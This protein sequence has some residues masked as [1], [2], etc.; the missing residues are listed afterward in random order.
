MS[1]LVEV[2]PPRYMKS[3][4]TATAPVVLPDLQSGRRRYFAGIITGGVLLALAA[5]EFLAG[6]VVMGR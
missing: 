5:A 4:P 6:L 1:A 2:D 3:I